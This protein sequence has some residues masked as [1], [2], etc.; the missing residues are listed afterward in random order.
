M[1][2]PSEGSSMASRSPG[3]GSVRTA[4]V[5]VDETAGRV[6]IVD[7]RWSVVALFC[8]HCGHRGVWRV[9]EPYSMDDRMSNL[10]CAECEVRFDLGEWPRPCP[11]DPW[12][13][14]IADVSKRGR[15]V[16]KRLPDHVLA[17]S[18]AAA[19]ELLAA[20]K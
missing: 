8:P 20:L 18:P 7:E 9:A 1:I 15:G 10:I 2:K 19:D 14:A 16:R 12:V 3:I 17:P 13:K 11:S 4:R 5:V 6:G